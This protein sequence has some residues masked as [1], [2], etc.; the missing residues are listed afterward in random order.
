MI[1]HHLIESENFE[2]ATKSQNDFLENNK[3]IVV[4]ISYF[5]NKVNE[6]HTFLTSYY[7]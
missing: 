6:N 2:Q 7:N 3:I 1:Q 5:F 4:N